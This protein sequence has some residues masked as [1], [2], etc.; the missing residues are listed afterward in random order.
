WEACGEALWPEC[1][2][3]TAARRS[4]HESK[5]RVD[6]RAEALDDRLD[7]PLF[8]DEGRGEED[9][10]APHAADRPAHRIDHQ[11]ARHRLALDL[12]VQLQSRVARRL[13]CAVGDELEGAE[14]PAAANVAHMRVLPEAI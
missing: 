3:G 4:F 7:M 10:V 8:H 5:R 9:M 14:Q 1:D 6:C 13:G 2:A 11:S 12:G